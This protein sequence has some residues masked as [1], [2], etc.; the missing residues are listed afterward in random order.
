MDLKGEKIAVLAGGTSS[1]REV[2]LVSGR[3]VYE[4]L[5]E[6]GCDV[7]LVDPIDKNFIE[8]LKAAGT[9]IAFIALHGSFGEDGTVQHLLDEAGIPYTGSGPF[10]SQLAFDKS[11]AQAL[12]KK[13]AFRIPEFIVFGKLTDFRGLRPFSLPVVVKPAMAGSSVGVTIVR[14]ETEYEAACLKAFEHS[15]KVLVEQFIEGRELTVGILGNR[16]LPAVEV[17][18]KRSFYDYEAKYQDTGTTYECPAKLSARES[19]RLSQVALDAF[20]ALGCEVMARAD[21][22]LSRQGEPFLLEVNTIPG[23]TGKSLLPKA[24]KAS[25]IEFYDLCTKIL[26]LSLTKAPVTI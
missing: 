14:Q 10:A 17:L 1:E 20:H 11:Q 8:V 5:R 19:V 24:A 3:A 25:G 18:P 13:L 21:F 26:E 16:A 6:K 23:L 2:S 4:A 15:N 22:I 12:F 9:T 7:F